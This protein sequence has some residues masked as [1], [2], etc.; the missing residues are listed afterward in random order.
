MTYHGNLVHMG[1]RQ[2]NVTLIN[3]IYQTTLTNY[4]KIHNEVIYR[5]LCILCS[6]LCNSYPNS[7][8]RGNNFVTQEQT[9]SLVKGWYFMVIF[10]AFR[11][12]FITENWST[13]KTILKKPNI[14]FR[15]TDVKSQHAAQTYCYFQI[16]RKVPQFC[17]KESLIPQPVPAMQACTSSSS[18]LYFLRDRQTWKWKKLDA[19]YLRLHPLEI[20][21]SAILASEMSWDNAS[22]IQDHLHKHTGYNLFLWNVRWDWG[23]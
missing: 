11:I 15:F 22:H 7:A 12:Q 5:A 10:D 8:K 19:E 18:M 3:C 9:P 20:P 2:S 1:W 13:V 14:L 6:I 16:W 17:T 21:P 4:C 23:D